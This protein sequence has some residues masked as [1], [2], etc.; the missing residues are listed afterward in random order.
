[1]PAP[2]SI[3]DSNSQNALRPTN[4]TTK[5]LIPPARSRLPVHNPVTIS[6]PFEP[7][8]VLGHSEKSY[9]NIPGLRWCSCL[10]VA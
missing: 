2:E 4:M 1:M 8:F 3:R 6:Q 9:L 5:D 7:D 10:L